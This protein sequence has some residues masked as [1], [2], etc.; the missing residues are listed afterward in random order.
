MSSR[1]I[2]KSDSPRF[3]ALSSTIDKLWNTPEES[4]DALRESSLSLGLR[5]N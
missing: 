2:D 1:L 3:S 5:C 4:V